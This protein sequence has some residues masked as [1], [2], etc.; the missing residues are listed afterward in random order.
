MRLFRRTMEPVKPQHVE[1]AKAGPM[2]FSHDS[3]LGSEALN[4]E[5]EN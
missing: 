4:L 1:I 3:E 2:R 5:A